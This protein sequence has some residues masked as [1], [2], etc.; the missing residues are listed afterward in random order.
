MHEAN[1]DPLVVVPPFDIEGKYQAAS[2]RLALDNQAYAHTRSSQ[3]H[4]RADRSGVG[5]RRSLASQVGLV[6][7]TSVA[8]FGQYRC[9]AEG[10]QANGSPV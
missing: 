7:G 1:S 3:H 9:S 10:A 5:P 8:G 2:V 6:R 4:Q